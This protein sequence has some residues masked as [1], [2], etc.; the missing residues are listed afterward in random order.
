MRKETEQCPHYNT[1]TVQVVQI[2]DVNKRQKLSENI[3][4]R[5]NKN[6]FIKKQERHNFLTQTTHVK[7]PTKNLH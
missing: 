4:R 2:C 3:P 1:K 5:L 6:A 7:S